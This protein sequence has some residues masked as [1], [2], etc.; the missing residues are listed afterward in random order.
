[1]CVI[2]EHDTG[3]LFY[4]ADGNGVGVGGILFATVG[5]ALGLTN[6]DFVVI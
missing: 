3:D 6:A 1:M 2:Y 5:I 4:D